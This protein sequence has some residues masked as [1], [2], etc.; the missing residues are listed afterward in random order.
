MG[1]RILSTSERRELEKRENPG[2]KSKK[3]GA[4]K[5]KSSQKPNLSAPTARTIA[6]VITHS[7]GTVR[8]ENISTS[9]PT[10]RKSYFDRVAEEHKLNERRGQN[11]EPIPIAKPAFRVTKPNIR[12]KLA[13]MRSGQ[14]QL[15][16][17]RQK[18]LIEQATHSLRSTN[19][20]PNLPTK[21]LTGQ[22][23]IN[24][25][26]RRMRPFHKLR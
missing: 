22:K 21:P 5:Y 6:G 19:G 2:K 14:Q 13:L 16:R 18:Q 3:P 23:L 8:G 1:K 24:G 17:R 26:G 12:Q 20:Q 11:P 7:L 4:K 10:P 25:P 15:A 9:Q